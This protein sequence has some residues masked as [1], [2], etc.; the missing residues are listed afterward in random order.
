MSWLLKLILEWASKLAPEFIGAGHFLSK[1]PISN[2]AKLS[3]GNYIKSALANGIDEGAI[4]RNVLSKFKTSK[5]IDAFS[6]ELDK[7]ILSQN[8]GE[9]MAILNSTW[10]GLSIAKWTPTT[11]NGLFGTLEVSMLGWK[12]KA[13]RIYKFG[14][15]ASVDG[16]V[17]P[18]V[19]RYDWLLLKNARLHAG[20][21]FWRLY[22]GF[23]KL[24]S[25]EIT[26][27][28]GISAFKRNRGKI[29]WKRYF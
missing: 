9:E 12:G 11:R 26:S 16:Y 20:T 5:Q 13:E 22:Y 27:W 17:Y 2:K 15:T 14:N 29:N 28:R 7:L 6:K 24:Q 21:L 10:L 19:R 25:G 8:K 4:M 23:H 18:L 1:T 3:I